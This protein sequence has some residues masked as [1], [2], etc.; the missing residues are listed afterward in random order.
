MCKVIVEATTA[1][2]QR[3]RQSK[4]SGLQ[5]TDLKIVAYRALKDH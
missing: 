3:K 1:A 5:N 2:V 4:A